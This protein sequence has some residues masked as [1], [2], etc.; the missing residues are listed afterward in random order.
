MVEW[1]AGNQSGKH[2]EHLTGEVNSH[3]P[4]TIEKTQPKL[5]LPRPA[6]DPANAVLLNSEERDPDVPIWQ[7]SWSNPARRIRVITDALP[8]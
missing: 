2:R 7:Q 8:L 4:A 6:E 1:R 3:G 5:H